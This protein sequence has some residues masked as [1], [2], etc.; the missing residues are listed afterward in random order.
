MGEYGAWA[1]LGTPQI[2]EVPPIIS[3]M[4]KAMNV[5]FG[6]YIQRVHAN[7]SRLKIRKKMDRGRIQG[8]PKFFEYPYY[9]GNG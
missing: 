4:D 7:K 5:R 9:L 8:M 1:N 2:Y 3:G 6:R